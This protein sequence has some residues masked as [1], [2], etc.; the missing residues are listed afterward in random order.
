VKDAFLNGWEKA[1][2]SFEEAKT[3]AYLLLKMSLRKSE[4]AKK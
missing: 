4:K 1:L 3:L 2:P